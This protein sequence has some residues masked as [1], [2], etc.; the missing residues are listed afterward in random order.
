[1]T[2]GLRAGQGRATCPAGWLYRPTTLITTP[3]LP[4]AHDYVGFVERELKYRRWMH[5]PPFGVLA[6]VLVQSQKLE[7]ADRLVRRAGQVFHS[8]P[9]HRRRACRPTHRAYRAHQGHITFI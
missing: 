7:E 9:E 4:Q 1:M 5:Y 3:L 6:S 2:Q 8:K